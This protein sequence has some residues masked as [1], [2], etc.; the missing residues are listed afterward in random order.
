MGVV[1]N[2]ATEMPHRASYD[3]SKYYYSGG[4]QL[5]APRG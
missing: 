1:L 3:Y 5:P 4:Q 2:R